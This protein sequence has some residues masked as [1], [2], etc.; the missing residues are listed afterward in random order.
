MNNFLEFFYY[1]KSENSQ[2]RLPWKKIARE[3]N[4][5]LKTLNPKHSSQCA[6]RWKNHLS[7]TFKKSFN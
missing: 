4:E 1:V 6:E 5:N 2:R 7:K 3:L